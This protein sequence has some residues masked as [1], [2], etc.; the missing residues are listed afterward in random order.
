MRASLTTSP[1]AAI[2]TQG[3]RPHY[4][5]RVRGPG[6][7]SGPWPWPGINFLWGSPNIPNP[8]GFAT[9]LI[10]HIR[11]DPIGEDVTFGT[12]V[13]LLTTGKTTQI[14]ILQPG[15]C[16]SIQLL[17]ISG[18]YATCAAGL[19]SVVACIIKD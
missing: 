6:I 2:F 11:N 18:L 5:V 19:E 4:E 10:L 17:K 14:G 15:E 13:G 9:P 16:V 8:I 12:L 1:I 7:G 3:S